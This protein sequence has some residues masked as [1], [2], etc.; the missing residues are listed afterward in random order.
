MGSVG[1]EGKEMNGVREILVCKECGATDEGGSVE[2]SGGK[3]Y[4]FRKIP[5]DGSP[6]PLLCSG[7]F[8]RQFEW[9]PRRKSDSTKS[10]TS[11]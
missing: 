4:H 3:L 5:K 6:Y 10:H 11:T 1:A 2:Y 7:E 9:A 8:N